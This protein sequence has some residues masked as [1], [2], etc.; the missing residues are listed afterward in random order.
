[1]NFSKPERWSCSGGVW[2]RELMVCIYTLFFF[3][4]ESDLQ[5]HTQDR[6]AE[7]NS[8]EIEDEDGDSEDDQENLVSE[9][10]EADLEEGESTY[11][12]ETDETTE[13]ETEEEDFDGKP[14]L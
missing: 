1:M 14:D 13:T 9:C 6:G 8:E 10:E 4:S 7:I 11:D 5:H 2:H 12:T 3:A